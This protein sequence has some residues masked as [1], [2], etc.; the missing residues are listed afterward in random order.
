MPSPITTIEVVGATGSL[1]DPVCAGRRARI[2]D[3]L[4]RLFALG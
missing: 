1:S 4:L 2:I 3:R